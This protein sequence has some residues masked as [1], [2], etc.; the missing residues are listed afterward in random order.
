MQM[1]GSVLAEFDNMKLVRAKAIAFQIVPCQID[2]RSDAD[3]SANSIPV[4]AGVIAAGIAEPRR[5]VL[6]QL[7]H[8]FA[9]VGRV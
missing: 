5:S 1:S 6:Y 2:A 7:P 4:M 3:L 9:I 8:L